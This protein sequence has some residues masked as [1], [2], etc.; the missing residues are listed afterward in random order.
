MYNKARVF[1]NLFCER[2]QDAYVCSLA[3]AE[4]LNQ[5]RRRHGAGFKCRI[6][7]RIDQSEPGDLLC[8]YWNA[9]IFPYYNSTADSAIIDIREIIVTKNRHN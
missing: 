3:R 8:Y 6:Q 9:N 2:S 4:L 1:K 5:S 7:S